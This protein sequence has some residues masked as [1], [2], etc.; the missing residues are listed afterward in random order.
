MDCTGM[1]PDWGVLIDKILTGGRELI[2]HCREFGAEIFV[3]RLTGVD[4]DFKHE[5]VYFK[6]D[7]VHNCGRHTG[8]TGIDIRPSLV[9]AD[10]ISLQR[11]PGAEDIFT[12]DMPFARSA[13][14]VLL[15]TAE[16]R[17]CFKW[18]RCQKIEA[19]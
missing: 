14:I 5:K 19:A 16:K 7:R 1:T 11:K 6:F 17:Y 15:G 3:F 18:D 13:E 9:F 8:N 12:V 10:S 4:P 2:C